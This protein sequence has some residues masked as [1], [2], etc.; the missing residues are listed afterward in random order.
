MTTFAPSPI[1]TTIV[2]IYLRSAT[3]DTD[4]A[5]KF[6]QQET[7]CRVYCGLNDLTIG[8]VYREIAPGLDYRNNERLRVAR[9]RCQSGESSGIVVM[10]I[11]RVS[12]SQVHQII[13]LQELRGYG[14]TLYCAYERIEAT[15]AGKALT[16][17]MQV[18]DDVEREKQRLHHQ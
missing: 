12:R 2:D 14:A 11:D 10:S 15:P 5:D 16:T 13:F 17:I 1:R 6:N 9:G 18:M 4:T 7:I 8:A 3:D